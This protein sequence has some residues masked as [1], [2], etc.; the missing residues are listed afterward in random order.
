MG[1]IAAGCGADLA[2]SVKIQG[3]GVTFGRETEY[4]DDA[5]LSINCGFT[6]PIYPSKH[7]ESVHPASIH[8]RFNLRAFFDGC[9]VSHHT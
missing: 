5:W 6:L 4:S 8:L 2:N 9:F 3:R 7:A 1:L